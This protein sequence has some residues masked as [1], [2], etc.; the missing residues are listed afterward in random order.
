M[1]NTQHPMC[2]GMCPPGPQVLPVRQSAL[3]QRPR[4]HVRVILPPQKNL[5]WKRR[6]HPEWKHC[7]D[8]KQETRHQYP[9]LGLYLID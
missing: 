8:P 6:N 9:A 3:S 7:P 1:G 5:N 2:T 4:L